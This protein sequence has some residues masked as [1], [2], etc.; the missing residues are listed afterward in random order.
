MVLWYCIIILHYNVFVLNCTA[1]EIL[2]Q[3]DYPGYD[4]SVVTSYLYRAFTLIEE[5]S[6]KTRRSWNTSIIIVTG[7]RL[8]SLFRPYY[9]SHQAPFWHLFIFLSNKDR[10]SYPGGDS[11]GASSRAEAKNAE[12]FT[13]TS[14]CSFSRDSWANKVTA[15]ALYSRELISNRG[16][17]FSV[18][19]WDQ[20]GCGFYQALCH[21][22]TSHSF[23][24]GRVAWA[25]SWWLLNSWIPF[26]SHT[27]TSSCHNL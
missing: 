6:F 25:W 8:G 3:N 19:H 24:G 2:V 10:V 23:S 5:N 4:H 15:Y 18:R 20:T 26:P 13:Y 9:P 21:F 12:I 17:I 1:N 11:A 14:P 27:H 7:Y 16:R 22:W